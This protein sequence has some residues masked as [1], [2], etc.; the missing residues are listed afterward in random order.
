MRWLGEWGGRH[1]RAGMAR[2]GGTPALEEYD[3]QGSCR[4]NGLQ[5][6]TADTAERAAA[7]AGHGRLEEREEQRSGRQGGGDGVRGGWERW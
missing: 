3:R 5:N 7:A 6:R 4:C 2:A 1:G